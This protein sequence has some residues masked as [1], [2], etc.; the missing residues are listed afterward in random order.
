MTQHT[1]SMLRYTADHMDFSNMM[2][3]SVGNEAVAR[4]LANNIESNGLYVYGFT[5][6]GKKAELNHLMSDKHISYIY[7]TPVA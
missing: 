6:T 5:L 7:T 1:V 4:E 3:N 2:D